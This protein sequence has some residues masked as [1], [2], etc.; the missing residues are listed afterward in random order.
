MTKSRDLADLASGIDVADLRD[1]TDGELITW[2][3]N[4][5]P[6]TVSVGTVGHVLTSN[7]AGAKPSFQSG[8]QIVQQVRDEE[9][10]YASYS[11]GITIAYD[12]TIPQNSEGTQVFEQAITPTSTSNFLEFEVYI[13]AQ[14]GAGYH[15]AVALFKDSETDATDVGVL[16][17]NGGFLRGGIVRFRVPVAAASA[18]T[19]KV[20]IGNE[21]GSTTSINGDG[22]SR[23]YGGKLTSYLQI[24]EVTY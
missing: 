23:K 18:Q 1:G 6:D 21:G 7:G 10:A 24:R 16:G 20:R 9:T 14:M 17:L 4:G 8:K 5:N 11:S 15:L 2:D 19:W 13:N 12:D 22:S 3:A